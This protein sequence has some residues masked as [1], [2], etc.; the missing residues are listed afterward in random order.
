M[1]KKIEEFFEYYNTVQ[2]ME[3]NGEDPSQVK[4]EYGNKT[5]NYEETRSALD[6]LASN[7]GFV[8]EKVRLENEMRMNT[9]S[10]YLKKLLPE[11]DIEGLDNTLK[12][13]ERLM[14]EPNNETEEN[15]KDAE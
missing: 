1:S 8:L 6:D 7:I 13:L 3:Q 4:K 15:E 2:E 11:E 14:E 10:N 12:E 9:L 5:M